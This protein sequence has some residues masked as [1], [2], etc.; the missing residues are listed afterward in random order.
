MLADWD[1]E[2]VPETDAE[3]ELDADAEELFD[4]VPV[5]DGDALW[6]TEDE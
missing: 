3:T 5:V 1:L 4:F 6:L 2:D